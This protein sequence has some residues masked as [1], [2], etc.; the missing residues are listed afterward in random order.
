[1]RVFVTGATGFVG[2]RLCA[3]LT[4]RGDEVVAHTRSPERARALLPAP[5]RVT[6]ALAEA[7]GCDAVVS[8]AGE[9]VLGR[10]WNEAHKAALWSSR[11]DA[12]RAVVAA[13]TGAQVIVSAS[14]IGYY[15]DRGDEELDETSPPGDDHLARLCV[16][17]EE[18]AAQPGK[19]TVN[20]RLGVILGGGGGALERM[21]PPFRAFVGGPVGSGRQWVS[22]IHL[23]D[24]LGLIRLALDDARAS[25]PINATAPEPARMRDFA[26][27]LG[28]A[29]GRPSWLP[30]PAFALKLAFGEGAAV[31]L[32]SQRVLPRRAHALGY[33]WKHPT[34]ADALAAAVEPPRDA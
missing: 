17:W 20:L 8:L 6:D 21:I 7:A 14:A 19:R 28:R 24:V 16:A 23:D 22:F 11:V 26:A 15:G 2:R 25:G 32:A 33:V 29:L 13:A 34:L 3:E 5:V 27:A 1:M 31:L 4:A 12:T 9:P 18:A 30:V 10:R